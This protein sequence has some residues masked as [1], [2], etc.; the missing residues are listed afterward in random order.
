MEY[1]T[2]KT[3]PKCGSHSFQIF[4][5]CVM[6]INYSVENGEVESNGRCDDSD[7]LSIT[8]NCSECGHMWHPRNRSKLFETTAENFL[9]QF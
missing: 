5:K 7:S 4:E 8:C 9:K 6:V 2:D 1:Y 3:C